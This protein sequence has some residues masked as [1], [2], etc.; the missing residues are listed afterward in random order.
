MAIPGGSPASA[1]GPGP[2]TVNYN[3]PGTYDVSLSVSGTENTDDYTMTDYISVAANL[4]EL[5]F[6]PDCYGEETS[7]ELQNTNGQVIYSV[8]NGYYPGGNTAQDMEPNPESIT[9]NWCLMD[10]CYKFVVEDEYG[11]G[12]Y[13]SQHT[14][15]FDGDFTIYDNDDNILAELNEPN[16]DFGDDITLNFCVES[17]LSTSIIVL[18]LHSLIYF[19][20]LLTELL[21]LRVKSM[22]KLKYIT[23]FGKRFIRL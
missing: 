20:I 12:L 19:L 16:S 13:G 5:D 2:H 17:G 14:C 21:F 23:P 11:D 8:S 7:W 18:I 10:G 1:N 3:S 22:V 15:E 6:L 4:V 9:E